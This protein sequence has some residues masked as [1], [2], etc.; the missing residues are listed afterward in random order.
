MNKG[1]NGQPHRE[2]DYELDGFMVPT[3][4]MVGDA[5]AQHKDNSEDNLFVYK[6]KVYN[7]TR[8]NEEK[9]NYVSVATDLVS[10]GELP[11]PPLRRNSRVMFHWW[12]KGGM[13]MWR[14]VLTPYRRRRQ[15]VPDDLKDDKYWARRRKNNMAAKRSRD[16]RRMKENQIALRAGYLEKEVRLSLCPRPYAWFHFQVKEYGVTARSGTAEKGEPY[17][18]REAVEVRGRI[19]PR[20]HH[21][22]KHKHAT[23][24]P[25]GLPAAP[26]PHPSPPRDAAA[27]DEIRRDAPT[28][29]PGPIGLPPWLAS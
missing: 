12:V 24:S 16:A 8:K 13:S 18:P 23:R 6:K 7:K 9:D 15:F 2:C 10:G 28:A 14:D 5:R 17:P 3:L 26:V 1:S 29:R 25:R 21:P 4:L 27:A 11:P 20:T 19:D 22:I